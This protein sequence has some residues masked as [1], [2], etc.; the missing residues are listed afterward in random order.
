M[1]SAEYTGAPSSVNATAPPSASPP[2]SA[3]SFPSRFLVT[4][5]MGNTLQNP[6]R[7]A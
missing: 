7:S 5:P 4:A 1:I 3:S 6:A 2:S